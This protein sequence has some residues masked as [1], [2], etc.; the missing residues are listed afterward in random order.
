MSD[1]DSAPSPAKKIF[2][3]NFPPRRVKAPEKSPDRR[4]PQRP[5]HVRGQSEGRLC[6]VAF[7]P[8]PSPRYVQ[9]PGSLYGQGLADS[10]KKKH[11]STSKSEI[12]E[13]SD[14]IKFALDAVDQY[15]HVDRLVLKT[16]SQ[17]KNEDQV[18]VSQKMFE[19]LK[20]HQIEGIKFMWNA[21]FTTNFNAG[22]I[23]AHCMGL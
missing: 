12:Q 21:C 16:G 6:Q 23:L 3:P 13:S 8:R 11:A 7:Q 4:V 19:A 20:H 22:C 14:P 10:G 9:M 17:I 15:Q 18:V 1:S 2:T 5:N